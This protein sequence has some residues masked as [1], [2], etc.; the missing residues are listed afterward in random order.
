MTTA[1]AA[2][3][4]LQREIDIRWEIANYG[5]VR[6]FNDL[7][8]FPTKRNDRIRAALE[9]IAAKLV[10]DGV[11]EEE[12]Q[13]GDDSLEQLIGATWAEIEK[14]FKAWAAR[15]PQRRDV[16]HKQWAAEAAAKAGTAA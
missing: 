11:L 7:A 8:L 6:R 10:D 16:I 15:A 5:R 3:D 2:A 12:M 4:A 1:T 14:L 13:E 9:E